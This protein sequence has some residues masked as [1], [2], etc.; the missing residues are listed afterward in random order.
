MIDVIIPHPSAPRALVLDEGD[1][2]CLPR[3]Y[4]SWVSLN[5]DSKIVA[6][7]G[8][9]SGVGCM[10]WLGRCLVDG[11]HVIAFITMVLD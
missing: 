2:W 7:L 6:I 5:P 4:S 11:A 10:C 3:G 9:R 1:H 8:P